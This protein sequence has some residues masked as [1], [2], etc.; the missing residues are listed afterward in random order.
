MEW[1]I[2]MVIGGLVFVGFC[3]NGNSANDAAGALGFLFV[4]VLVVFVIGNSISGD[5]VVITGD[6]RM[7]DTGRVLSIQQ[8]AP[9]PPL[10]APSELIPLND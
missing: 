3:G 6:L 5:K 8:S 4:I 10:A 9:A 7:P 2:L 1:I